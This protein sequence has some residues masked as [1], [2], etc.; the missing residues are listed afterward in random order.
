MKLTVLLDNNT[1][2]DRYLIGEPGVCYHIEIGGRNILFDTGYS[3]IFIKNAEFLGLDLK[4][5]DTIV[6]SHGHNDHS[7]GLGYL[8]QHFDRISFNPAPKINLVAHPAAFSPKFDGNKSI[9]ANF[10]ADCYSLYLNKVETKQPYY[11]ADNLIFLGEIKRL[12]DFE[13]LRPAG[14]TL[15]CCGERVSDWVPDDS[16][17]VYTSA[18]GIVVITGCS[19]SGICNI[20]DY[21]ISVTGDSRVL[22]VIGGFHLLNANEN[23]LTKTAEH[24]SQINPQ[25]L[26]PCHCTDLNAKLALAK[27]VDIDEVGVGTVLEFA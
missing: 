18:E 22:A 21:A 4:A 9:G 1:L 19:H 16:A 14:E 20:V 25:H 8:M 15:D 11:I 26:Y 17:I 5:V 27:R 2:I 10:P 7:W 23:V 24:L 13:G 12:N 3:D 6:L